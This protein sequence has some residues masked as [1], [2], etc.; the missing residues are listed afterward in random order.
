M[1][2]IRVHVVAASLAALL[3]TTLLWLLFTGGN[4]AAFPW[5]VLAVVPLVVFVLAFPRWEAKRAAARNEAAYQAYLAEDAEWVAEHGDV[6]SVYRGES[7]G[8]KMHALR[9]RNPREQVR[10]IL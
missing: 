5:P 6:N 7:N 4:T 9:P 2:D 3:F 1:A 8:I 10:R